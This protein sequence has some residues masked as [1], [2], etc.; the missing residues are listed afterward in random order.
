MVICIDVGHGTDTFDKTGGKGIKGVI[1]ENTLNALVAVDLFKKLS[2]LKGVKVMYAQKPDM[3]DIILS[4]RV[5]ISNENKADLFISIHHD[6]SSNPEKNGFTFYKWHT[7]DETKKLC[8]SMT[9]YLKA[10]G[11]KAN[12]LNIQ[13][14]KPDNWNNFYV[15]RE[16][17]AP[18]ILLEC[19]FFTNKKDTARN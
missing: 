9:S 7:N 18:A 10:F 3:T 17:K 13:G 1:E 2:N 19:G 4:K 15:V 6:A 14:C 11:A 16:T 5:E 8:E 12:S